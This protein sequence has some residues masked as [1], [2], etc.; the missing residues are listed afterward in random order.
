MPVTPDSTV[1]IR[2]GTLGVLGS[3]VVVGDGEGERGKDG[4]TG[5]EE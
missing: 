5:G 3:S 1:V 4:E 2:L